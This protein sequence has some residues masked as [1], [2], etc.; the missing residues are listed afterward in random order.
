MQLPMLKSVSSAPY[1]CVCLSGDMYW[2]PVTIVYFVNKMRVQFVTKYSDRYVSINQIFKG[3]IILFSVSYIV[4]YYYIR[5]DLRVLNK[6]E[7]S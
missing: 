5:P 3:E 2:F 4:K 7:R 1:I 6:I